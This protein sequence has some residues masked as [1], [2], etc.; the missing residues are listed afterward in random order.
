M[1]DDNRNCEVCQ[2]SAP[3]QCSACKAAFYCTV[4]HQKQHWKE[5]KAPCKRTR[6]IREPH[7][8]SLG[9]DK[10][11]EKYEWF[12][13]CYRLKLDDD[14]A[15]R[16]ELNGLYSGS[17]DIFNDFLVFCKLSVKRRAV[18]PEWDWT[19]FL[20]KA[21][22]LVNYAFEKSDATEKYGSENIFAAAV[23]G[24]SLRY[25]ASQIFLDFSENDDVRFDLEDLA[26]DLDLDDSEDWEF[27]SGFFVDVG[28]SEPWKMFQMLLDSAR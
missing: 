24:R 10:E 22:T 6:Q 17:D 18:P 2:K 13:D 11:G 3:L 23:G 8:W 1:S 19:A 26:S 4:E 28:G 27:A 25:T 5:H 16:G 12:T 20:T 21:A 15:L 14:Y 7:S 9:L